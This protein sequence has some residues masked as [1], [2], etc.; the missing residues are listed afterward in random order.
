MDGM[1]HQHRDESEQHRESAHLDP[2]HNRWPLT[3]AGWRTLPQ[4]SDHDQ[5]RSDYFLIAG[6]GGDGSILDA[7]SGRVTADCS[8]VRIS[9]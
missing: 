2:S 8:K 6:I 5:T 4:R 7:P 3:I 1:F 9:R